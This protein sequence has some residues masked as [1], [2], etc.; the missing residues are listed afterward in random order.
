MKSGFA[1]SDSNTIGNIEIEGDELKDISSRLF[2]GT[3]AVSSASLI[4][5]NQYFS[6]FWP[7]AVIFGISYTSS[8]LSN[9]WEMRGGWKRYM[10]IFSVVALLVGLLTMTAS[11]MIIG[12]V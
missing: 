3:V 8:A 10:I 1:E 12:V 5:E 11:T 4:G 7:L 6:L 2:Y 9:V